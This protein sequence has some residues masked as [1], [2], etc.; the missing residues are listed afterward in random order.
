MQSI[1]YV[2]AMRFLL[3]SFLQGVVRL[4]GVLPQGYFWEYGLR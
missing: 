2:T 1:H 3:E 4:L